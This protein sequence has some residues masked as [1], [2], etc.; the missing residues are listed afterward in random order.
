V[1]A[2]VEPPGEADLARLYAGEAVR[3]QA[4][5]RAEAAAFWWTQALV[6]ALVVDDTAIEVSARRHL[7]AGRRLD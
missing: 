7:R 4:R 3:E 2:A 5:G 1:S 6:M